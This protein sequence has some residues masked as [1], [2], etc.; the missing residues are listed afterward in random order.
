[1]KDSGEQLRELLKPNGRRGTF[2][3]EVVRL[4]LEFN[5]R[6][7]YLIDQDGDV[8]KGAKVWKLSKKQLDRL[9]RFL[10]ARINP[11]TGRIPRKITAASQMVERLALG[12]HSDQ[13]KVDE[14]AIPPR[15]HI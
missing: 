5:N 4:R 2:D 7:V 14:D 15:A 3:R 11:D 10:L 8:M 13:N 9:S 12:I 6:T 1:F